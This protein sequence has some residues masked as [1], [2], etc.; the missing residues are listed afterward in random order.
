M[1]TILPGDPYQYI[2]QIQSSLS[3][4]LGQVSGAVGLISIP[5]I[6]LYFR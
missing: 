6:E 4:P 5:G 1:E 3:S 2:S